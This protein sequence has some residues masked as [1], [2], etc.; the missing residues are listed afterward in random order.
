MKFRIQLVAAPIAAP[1]VR[2]V[3]E[4]ISVGYT[5]EFRQI[6]LED[7]R[8]VGTLTPWYTLHSNPEEHVVEEEE[9]HGCGCNLLC[10]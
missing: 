1:F 10:M 9:C 6:M 8:I 7:D 2:M 5:G 4:L 3:R